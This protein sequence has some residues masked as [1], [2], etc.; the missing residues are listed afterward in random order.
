MAG[1]FYGGAMTKRPIKDLLRQVA[2]NIFFC[3]IAS[4]Q[5]FGQADGAEAPPRTLIVA[6]KETPPFAMKQSD[7]SW[8]GMSIDL[9]ES[10]AASLGWQFEYREMDLTDMLEQVSDGRV[11]AAVSAITV[12]AER[13]KVADFTYPYFGAG[14]GLAYLEQEHSLFMVILRNFFSW[15]FL[16][17][18][19]AL[20]LVLL[21]AGAAVWVFERNRN[22][23]QFGGKPWFGLGAGFWWSAVTMTTVGYGDK[24][25]QTLGGRVV[26]LVWMFTSI[27][28]ISTFTASIASS[29]TVDRLDASLLKSRPLESLRFATVDGTTGQEYA[30]RHGYRRMSFASVDEALDALA[31]REVDAV[32]YDTPILKYRSLRESERNLLIWPSILKSEEYAILLPTKSALTESLN[33]AI[34]EKIRDPSWAQLQKQYLG[35]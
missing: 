4:S 27:I 11:D 14:L 29:V 1:F 15:S 22:K 28:V 30:D 2:T 6:T 20:V 23:E 13:E 34:I 9:W 26:A 18:V 31:T 8:S 24:A 16:S 32:L 19:L 10:V 12:T 5:A 7:G 25:P 33:V 21:A 3:I 35:N 17:A